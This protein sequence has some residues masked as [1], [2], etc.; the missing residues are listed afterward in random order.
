MTDQDIIHLLVGLASNKNKE[1]ISV[2]GSVR[3]AAIQALENIVIAHTEC[4]GYP[5][6]RVHNP[7]KCE[8]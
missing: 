7:E 3:V 4:Q 8:T 6:L 5:Y 2:S 1:E